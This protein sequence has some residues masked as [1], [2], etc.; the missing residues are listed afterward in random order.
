MMKAHLVRYLL[1][2]AI[3]IVLLFCL[4]GCAIS[5]TSDLGKFTLADLDAAIAIANAH[6]DKSGAACFQAIKDQIDS[7]TPLPVVGV[8]SAYEAGRVTVAAGIP[9]A[10]RLNCSAVALP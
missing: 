3:G 5:P 2:V 8:A 9:Q 1:V 7:H 10:V 4:P 6:G